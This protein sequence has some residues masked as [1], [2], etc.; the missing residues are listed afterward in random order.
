MLNIPKKELAACLAAAELGQFLH[1][2]LKIDKSCFCNSLATQIYVCFNLTKPLNV[3]T[4]FVA[5]RV[6]KIRNWGFTFKYVNTKENPGDI[7]SRGSDLLDL[8]YTQIEGMDLLGYVNPRKNGHSLFMIFH[9]SIKSEG[10]KK[11]QIFSFHSEITTE[12]VSLTTPRF[13]P[14]NKARK[15]GQ[16]GSLANHQ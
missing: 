11:Q 12:H 1:E 14:V 2:E 9:K 8:N 10:F 7:C 13:H 6:E 5:N 4:P 3:L 15:V 16:R